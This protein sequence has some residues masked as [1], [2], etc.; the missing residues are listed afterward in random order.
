MKIVRPLISSDRARGVVGAAVLAAVSLVSVLLAS[1]L[2]VVVALMISGGRTS[3]PAWIIGLVCAPGTLVTAL[4]CGGRCIRVARDRKGATRAC[5]SWGLAGGCW[6][7][8]C[9]SS[10]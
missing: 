2:A 10:R 7:R 8:R 5:L 1:T 6:R 9:S 4:V 3:D